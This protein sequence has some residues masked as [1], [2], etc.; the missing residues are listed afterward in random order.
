MRNRFWLLTSGFSPTVISGIINQPNNQEFILL[1]NITHF[2]KV[3]LHRL[4]LG[5]QPL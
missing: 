4:Q 5:I 1:R 2:I 3:G